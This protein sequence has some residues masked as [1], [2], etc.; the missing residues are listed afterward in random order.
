MMGLITINLRTMNR[1][2]K[3]RAWYPPM[4]K[5]GRGTMS[6]EVYENNETEHLNHGIE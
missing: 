1:P 2:I 6:L 4:T 5:V 3:F